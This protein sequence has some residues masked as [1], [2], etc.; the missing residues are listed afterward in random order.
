MDCE[1]IGALILRLRRERGMTQRQLAQCLS[2]TDKAVSKWERGLGCPDV[3]LL[4]GLSAALGVELT[5]LLAGELSDGADAGGKM[6]NTT[7]YVCP[8]CGG[9]TMTTGEAELS[10]CGRRLAP[11]AAEK[12]AAGEGLTVERVE[13]EW[14][15]TRGHPMTKDHHIAFV[16]LATGDRVQL[17]RQYP[18]WDLS[19][20]IPARGHG[21]LLWYC[22]QHGLFYQLI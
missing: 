2:V 15:I 18:E 4:P 22:T 17:I 9:I 8:V 5:A 16:A 19:L 7:Y 13:D 1:K 3:S 20:R 6:K 10:C 21:K 14:F 12:A 11:L